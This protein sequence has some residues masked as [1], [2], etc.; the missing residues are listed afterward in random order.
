MLLHES[1]GHI[2][3]ARFSAERLMMFAPSFRR[4]EPPCVTNP[5][6]SSSG[7]RIDCV[8]SARPSRW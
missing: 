7:R 6:R 2:L 1:A 3:P 8:A 4:R 5:A